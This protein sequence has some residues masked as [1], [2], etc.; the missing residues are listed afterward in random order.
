MQG[1]LNK[2]HR[3]VWLSS[4]MPGRILYRPIATGSGRMSPFSRFRHVHSRFKI[5]CRGLIEFHPTLILVVIVIVIG[6]IV[7]G[8]IWQYPIE[9]DTQDVSL[10]LLY[11]FQCVFSETHWSVPCFD[12]K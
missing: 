11:G 3:R 7:C 8:I 2:R 9:D 1:L 10:S 4:L 6:V 12:N 5:R